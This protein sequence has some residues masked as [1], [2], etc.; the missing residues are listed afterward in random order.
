MD[1]VK[2]AGF[3][4]SATSSYIAFLYKLCQLRRGWRDLAYLTLLCTLALQC[5]TF[6][7]GA[8]SASS[9]TF[10]GV[11]NLAILFM[12]LAAVAFCVLAEALLLQWA[13]PLA[14]VRRRIRWWLLAGLGLDGLLVVLFFAGGAPVKPPAVLAT[15]SDDPILLTYLLLFISSQAIPCVTI[16]RQCIPYAQEASK[17]WLRRGLRLLACGAAMLFLYCVTRTVNIVSPLLGLP[18]GKWQLLPSIFSPIGIVV[19]SVALTMPSWGGYITQGLEWLKNYASYRAL[20]PLWHSLYEASPD[21]ALEPPTSSVSDLRYKLHRRVIEIRDGWRAL[22][23][24]MEPTAP[25]TTASV[26]ESEQATAEAAKIK[27]ALEAKQAGRAPQAGTEAGFDYH[28][29]KTFAAEVAWLKEVSV[30]YGRASR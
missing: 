6:T 17:P 22:R 4:L 28:D 21:I 12:H 13:N 24:Y 26:G 2:I 5:L 8:V 11:G 14:Q 20:H 16:F 1:T 27:Q 29:T 23:P 25:A 7:M 30:A 19:L 9:T 10:L 3:L 18:L 15:G